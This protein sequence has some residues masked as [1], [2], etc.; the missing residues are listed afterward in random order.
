MVFG[1]SQVC[2][3]EICTYSGPSRCLP[4]VA[5]FNVHVST[6]R[7]FLR[8]QGTS[9]FFLLAKRRSGLP[10]CLWLPWYY[11]PRS[12]M[13]LLICLLAYP[14]VRTEPQSE[15]SRNRGKK[16]MISWMKHCKGLR[17]AN[18]TSHV[19]GR[20]YTGRTT[21]WS[22]KNQCVYG[23]EN[24]IAAVTFLAKNGAAL[25]KSNTFASVTEWQDSGE[26]GCWLKVSSPACMS[27]V[28]AKVPCCLELFGC[29]C[30]RLSQHGVGEVLIPL[31]QCWRDAFSVFAFA[32]LSFVLVSRCVV[33]FWAPPLRPPR[34]LTRQLCGSG[35]VCCAEFSIIR[36]KNNSIYLKP[37]ESFVYIG[38]RVSISWLQQIP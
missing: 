7:D 8:V 11:E 16:S 25:P 21:F 26:R 30:R 10:C 20:R 6:T 24:E 19:T 9:L 36:L 18:Q 28:F 29:C 4:T 38:G 17:H 23:P 12:S 3:V 32:L 33:C 2:G 34:L 14:N 27:P 37:D 15:I 5:S 35:C 31:R 1:W 13:M 22:P